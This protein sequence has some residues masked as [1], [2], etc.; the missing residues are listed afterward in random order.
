MKTTK[1][2]NTE[3]QPPEQ[4]F[5]KPKPANGLHIQAKAIVKQEKF[6]KPNKKL[7]WDQSA[8]AWLVG[9]KRFPEKNF[10]T[11]KKLVEKLSRKLLKI[12]GTKVCVFFGEP[13]VFSELLIKHGS[14][15]D[16]KSIIL[17]EGEPSNC[18]QNAARLW[19]AKNQKYRLCTGYGLSDDQMWRR[20]SWL[21]DKNGNIIE[22][23]TH[24][25][26]YFGVGHT[27]EE[28]ELFY[29]MFIE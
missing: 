16:H 17:T 21:E 11:D 10:Y 7:Y 14:V 23:T 19:K 1:Q 12:G 20:H 25:L 6:Q 18:H 28:A 8:L 3:E 15:L 2:K 27:P 13:R 5:V 26:I 4:T 24:R 22:T 9:T 29:E